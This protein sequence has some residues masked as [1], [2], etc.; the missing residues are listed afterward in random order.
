M[1]TSGC[2][3]LIFSISS[4]SLANVTVTAIFL[5]PLAIASFIPLGW[6]ILAVLESTMFSLP[7]YSINSG[8][9][10]V[11]TSPD[12]LPPIP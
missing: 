4:I 12:T 1:L 9:G 5:Y 11:L 7:I 2:S 6:S 3:S 10:L 8:I